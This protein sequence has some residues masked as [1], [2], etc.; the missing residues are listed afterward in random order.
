MIYYYEYMKKLL[1]LYSL[2]FAALSFANELIVVSNEKELSRW[3]KE[4][5]MDDYLL[6]RNFKALLK[7]NKVNYFNG[8]L[9]V[10]IPPLKCLEN[11]ELPT[12]Y[13]GQGVSRSFSFFSDRFKNGEGPDSFLAN[14]AKTKPDFRMLEI[15]FGVGVLLTQVQVLFPQSKLTGINYAPIDDVSSSNDLGKVAIF[16]QQCSKTEWEKL[17]NK[18]ELIF[19]D[20][21]NGELSWIKSRSI[22]LVVSQ[23]TIQYL[24]SKDTLLKEIV[25]VIRPGGRAYLHIKNIQLDDYKTGKDSF[26]NFFLQIQKSNPDFKIVIFDSF[27]VRIERPLESSLAELNVPFL[28]VKSIRVDEFKSKEALL[29]YN[30]TSGKVTFFQ[31][32]KPARQIPSSSN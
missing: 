6:E 3:L 22:D 18:P 31:S 24:S 19:K 26:N 10:N 1:L 11:T 2:L 29:R 25:R 13:C 23:S 12:P 14:Y 21:D 30:S 15:G 28:R 5:G 7:Y 4:Q 16:H 27:L 9:L 32:I 8:G 17:P 20:L